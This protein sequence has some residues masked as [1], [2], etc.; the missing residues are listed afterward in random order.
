MLPVLRGISLKRSCTDLRRACGVCRNRE[1]RLAF[2]IYTDLYAI[3][4]GLG[5]P[6]PASLLN[7]VEDSQR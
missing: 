6:T 4:L 1:T 2:A 5:F 3:G 7:K